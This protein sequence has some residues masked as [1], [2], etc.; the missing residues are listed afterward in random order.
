MDINE[1]DGKKVSKHIIIFI[2]IMGFEKMVENDDE[3]CLLYLKEFNDKFNSQI[4][5]A[6]DL[7]NPISTK[8]DLKVDAN[9]IKKI[10]FSDTIVICYPIENI[11]SKGIKLVVYSL[12][13]SMALHFP[14]LYEKNMSL[15]GNISI[16]DMYINDNI[17]YGKGLIDAYKFEKNGNNNKQ[18]LIYFDKSILPYINEQEYKITLH[19]EIFFDIIG[20]LIQHFSTSTIN[21]KGT[22][23]NPSI[24]FIETYRNYIIRNYNENI[25]NYYILS[26][27][28]FLVE[29]FNESIDRYKIQYANKIQFQNRIAYWLIL[30]NSIKK[31]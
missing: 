22:Q 3:N 7:I 9:K 28:I 13:I 5:F 31:M 12:I 18:L 4:D 19:N 14:I 21:V 2:D 8:N 1:N 29:Y 24:F 20:V 27:Y 15:R 16:G 10:N 11:D 23:V 26:K 6:T 17:Y 30:S 25:D